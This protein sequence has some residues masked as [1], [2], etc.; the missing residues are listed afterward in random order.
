MV[1]RQRCPNICHKI[2]SGH[3]T[4]DMLPT[5]L[6]IKEVSKAIA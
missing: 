4:E 5:K 3:L 2:K 6:Q 1:E